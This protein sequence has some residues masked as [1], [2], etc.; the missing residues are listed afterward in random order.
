MK[1]PPIPPLVAEKCTEAQTICIKFL[2]SLLPIQEPQ[3]VVTYLKQIK[4]PMHHFQ[5]SDWQ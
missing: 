1:P 2:K 5:L 4:I 3:V